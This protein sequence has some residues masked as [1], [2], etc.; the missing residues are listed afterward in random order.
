MKTFKKIISYIVYWLIQLTWGLPMT[1]IGAVAVLGCLITGHKPK[2]FGPNIYFQ[3]GMGWG[4]IE[5]GGFFLCSKTCDMRTI[6]HEAGHGL[7]NLIWGPLMPFIISIP[8]AFRYWLRKMSTR[9]KKSLFNLFFLLAALIL[10]T[11]LAC[12]FGL[13]FSIKWLTI[14]FELL[15]MYFLLLSIWAT[16][17][18]IPKYDR[19]YVEYDSIWFE[20]QATN[21]GIKVYEKKED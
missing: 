5:L 2:T 12:L 3:V 15:R 4:G 7:Q 8:S 10:T 17:K 18:E 16:T 11:G 14:V 19:Q 9:L 21:W 20:G 1:L 6:Y 13:V